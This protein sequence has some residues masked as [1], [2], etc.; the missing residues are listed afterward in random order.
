MGW[1]K[2]G[3]KITYNPGDTYKESVG[4]TLYAIWEKE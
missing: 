3:A 4:T 2:S 1:Q